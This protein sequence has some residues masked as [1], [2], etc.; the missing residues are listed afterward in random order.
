MNVWTI[1]L[2]VLA[3]GCSVNLNQFFVA[4]AVFPSPELQF[5]DEPNFTIAGVTD[6]TYRGGHGS[7]TVLRSAESLAKATAS[8]GGVKDSEDP[9]KEVQAYQRAAELNPSETNFFDWGA[10]LLIHRATEPAAQ[11][12]A[13]GAHLFPESTRMQLGLAT[14]WYVAGAYAQ[15][16]ECFFAAADINPTDPKPYL[17]LGQIE[18]RQIIEMPEYEARMARFASLQP[19]NALANYLYAVTLWTRTHDP[20][21]ARP[22]LEKAV[23][24]D[25]NFGRAFLQLGVVD[26]NERNYTAAIAEYKRAADV[27]PDLEEAHYRLSETYRITGDR[28]NAAR[29]LAIYN[30][31]S[32]EKAGQIEQERRSL[33]QFVVDLRSR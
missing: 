13:K 23:A 30:Q 26:A 15:A 24:L 3:L 31:L 28:A 16:A 20:H 33:Q 17:F 25:P 9:L 2:P 8:L 32:K 1:A 12:F 10:E 22:L 29:E 27:T 18:A 14:A 21:Q 5:F 4:P 11:V 7:D 6:N 19:N